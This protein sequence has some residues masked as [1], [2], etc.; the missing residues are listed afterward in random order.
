MNERIR[1]LAAQA[2]R[3]D[4]SNWCAFVLPPPTATIN[5]EKFAGL[6]VQECAELMERQHPWITSVSASKLIRNHFGVKE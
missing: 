1:E 3:K 6:I 2:G 4:Y 5:L